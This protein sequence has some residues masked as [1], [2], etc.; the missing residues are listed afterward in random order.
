MIIP[1]KAITIGTID[2]NDKALLLTKFGIS[3][4]IE[5]IIAARVPTKT[6]PKIILYLFLKFSVL[7]YPSARPIIN[8]NPTPASNTLINIFN[9]I[10]P[11]YKEEMAKSHFQYFLPLWTCPFKFWPFNN[12]WLCPESSC[13][14]CFLVN[15]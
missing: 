1:I 2:Q 15:V 7:R 4:M 3:L 13:Y 14:T 6:V 12:D 5:E 11:M 9:I 8:A 10:P